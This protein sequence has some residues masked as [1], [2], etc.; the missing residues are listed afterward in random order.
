MISGKAVSRAL[1]G[2]F[3]VEAALVNKLLLASC[4]Q[5][6]DEASELELDQGAS[7]EMETSA[8]GAEMETYNDLEDKLYGSDVEKIHDLFQGIRDKSIPV[9]NAANSQSWR[10]VYRS[11]RLCLLKDHQQ[12]SCG[13]TTFNMWNTVIRTGNWSLHLVAVGKMV[14]LFSATGHINYA[15][16]SRLYLQLMSELPTDH[17]WLYQCFSKQG[18]HAVRM[19]SLQVLMRSIKIRGGLTRGRGMSDCSGFTNVLGFMML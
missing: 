11:T 5:N 15:K 12:Q 3:L 6:S 2:H 7:S 18:F 4:K 19:K 17:P 14:N 9:S 1:R 10:S 13:Y 8:P 16:S